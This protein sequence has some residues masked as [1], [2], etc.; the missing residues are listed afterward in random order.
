MRLV[1]RGFRMAKVALDNV[2]VSKCKQEQ[3]NIFRQKQ[4]FFQKKITKTT[5]LPIATMFVFCFFFRKRYRENKPQIWEKR[6]QHM[7]SGSCNFSSLNS[8]LI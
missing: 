8:S 7:E 6:A 5:L 3:W 4:F 1:S 2:N